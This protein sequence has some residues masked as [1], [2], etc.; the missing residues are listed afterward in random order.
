MKYS[1]KYFENRSCRF[2][3]CHSGIEAM[4]CLFCFCPLYPYLDCGGNYRLTKEGIKDCS[5]CLKPH[6]PE[7]Y[8]LIIE[9]L[10]RLSDISRAS[11]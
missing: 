8:D 11:R 2:Y 10:K 4:N 7:N 1:Y 6:I 3:P 5:L 9:D